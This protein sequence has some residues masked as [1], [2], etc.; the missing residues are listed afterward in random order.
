MTQD[1][2]LNPYKPLLKSY[3]TN[4][5]QKLYLDHRTDSNQY[6][7]NQSEE[8]WDRVQNTEREKFINEQFAK[9][10]RPFSLQDYHQLFS[11]KIN[12]DNFKAQQDTLDKI[13]QDV[14]KMYA[15][16]T[17]LDEIGISYSFDITGGAVRDFTNNKPIK[18]LDIMLSIFDTYSNKSIL[19]KMNDISFLK[20]HF[21]IE[22]IIYYLQEIVTSAHEEDFIIKKQQLMTLCFHDYISE[23]FTFTS[24]NRDEEMSV[25]NIYEEN[26]LKR[27]RLL[28]VFKLCPEK[29]QLNYPIDILLTDFHKIEFIHD[30]DLDICKASFSLVN[31]IYKTTFPRNSLE[32]ISRFTAEL[33]FWADIHNKKITLNVDN[34][35]NK[36][37][38]SSITKHYKRLKEKYPDYELN[39]ISSKTF[40]DNLNFAKSIYLA[41][42]LRK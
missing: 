33:D 37:I 6:Y 22:S 29:M 38:E 11:S 23:K 7:L 35:S 17:K 2:V 41:E 13:Y 9:D 25:K 42:N 16:L 39:I 27:N 15:V 19:M 3:F 31:S 8:F 24:S 30:F 26:M 10:N 14:S 40:I 28:G 32:L 5:Y 34:M 18:D 20:K 21:K 4:T 1:T 36:T 12:L